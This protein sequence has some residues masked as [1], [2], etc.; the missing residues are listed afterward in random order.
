MLVCWVSIC[1]TPCCSTASVKSWDTTSTTHSF[2]SLQHSRRGIRLYFFLCS[3]CQLWRFKR[4]TDYIYAV[5]KLKNSLDLYPPSIYNDRSP[6]VIR[7]FEP[8][9]LSSIYTASP[10]IVEENHYSKYDESVKSGRAFKLRCTGRLSRLVASLD[11]FSE[12]RKNR[13]SIIPQ[14]N[15]LR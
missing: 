10:E 13:L 2:Q 11:N 1:V 14:N 15:S 3:Q 6:C 12:G 9:P 5:E 4:A 8:E 7:S